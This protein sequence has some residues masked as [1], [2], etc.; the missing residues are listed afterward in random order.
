MRTRI[1]HSNHPEVTK[2]LMPSPD[3]QLGVGAGIGPPH[4]TCVS[5]AAGLALSV[6]QML[7]LR[8]SGIRNRES[9]KHTAGTAIQ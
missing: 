9:T 1:L 7:F 5:Y 2:L 6:S 8:V 3:R 4:T